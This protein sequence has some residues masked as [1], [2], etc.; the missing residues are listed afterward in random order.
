MIVSMA[1]VMIG[2]IACAT[3]PHL[4]SQWIF[5]TIVA[6]FTGCGYVSLIALISNRTSNKHQGLVMGYLSTILYLAWMMTSFASGYLFA[7]LPVLPLMIAA[8]FVVVGFIVA[9][10]FASG[11]TAK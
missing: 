9:S 11:G 10:A 3:L 6:V 8:G 5:S 1:L 7:L 2:L 4:P